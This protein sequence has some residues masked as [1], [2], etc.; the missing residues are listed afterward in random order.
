LTSADVASITGGTVTSFDSVTKERP[1]ETTECE[2][3]TAAGSVRVNVSSDDASLRNAYSV[4]Q[5]PG[6]VSVPGLGSASDLYAVPDSPDFAQLAVLTTDERAIVLVQVEPQAPGSAGA[7][8]RI[9]RQ[10]V[11]VVERT[12]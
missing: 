6:T 8:E 12:S 11:G 3:T 7:L 10:V 9:A 1:L 2:W 4:S 5:P